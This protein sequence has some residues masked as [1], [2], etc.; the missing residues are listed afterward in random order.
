MA[1]V[2]IDKANVVREILEEHPRLQILLTDTYGVKEEDISA[3]RVD[4]DNGKIDVRAGG[5]NYRFKV[6][7]NAEVLAPSEKDPAILQLK[8]DPALRQAILLIVADYGG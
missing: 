5:R 1:D 6:K 3:I 4:G 2:T 7:G 8:L